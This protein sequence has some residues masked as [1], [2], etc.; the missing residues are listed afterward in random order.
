MKIFKEKKKIKFILRTII[1]EMKIMQATIRTM[2]RRW[3]IFS[4]FIIYLDAYSNPQGG[5]YSSSLN[6]SFKIPKIRCVCLFLKKKKKN[7][8]I[9]PHYLIECC[10]WYNLSHPPLKVT[11]TFQW[12]CSCQNPFLSPLCVCV[13]VCLFLK[14][15]E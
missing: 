7:G 1:F 13:C 9:V 10:V 3:I 14:K 4:K 11:M 8:L 12:S 5:S 2:L 6:A 15:K